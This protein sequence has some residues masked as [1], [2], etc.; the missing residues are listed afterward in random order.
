MFKWLAL[1]VEKDL[2][3]G[4]LG[5]LVIA[6]VVA[7]VVV[8][9]ETTLPPLIS[10]YVTHFCVPSLS[11]QY[12]STYLCSEPIHRCFTAIERTI[13][14]NVDVSSGDDL[15]VQAFQDIVRTFVQISVESQENCDKC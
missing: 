7:L 12:V 13:I 6:L 11:S 1:G 2:S 15:I 3:R 9:E 8:E 4:I 10:H 14:V 5:E